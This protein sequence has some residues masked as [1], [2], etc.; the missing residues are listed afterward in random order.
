M[1]I[2]ENPNGFIGTKLGYDNIKRIAEKEKEAQERNPAL[3]GVRLK[4]QAL[5][6]T[7]SSL[8]PTK[9]SDNNIRAI[10]TPVRSAPSGGNPL[11]VARPATSAPKMIARELRGPLI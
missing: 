10:S 4:G 1:V 6:L 7:Y 11:A 2:V 3:S 5:T 8:E 9:V